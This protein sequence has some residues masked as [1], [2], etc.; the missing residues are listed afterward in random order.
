MV[1]DRILD[2]FFVECDSKSSERFTSDHSNAF[3][4]DGGLGPCIDWLFASTVQ[5]DSP[6]EKAGGASGGSEVSRK[7]SI[8]K[9]P[10]CGKL[11]KGGGLCKHVRKRC[12]GSWHLS[13]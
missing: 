11:N 7:K 4:S 8:C 1:H 10:G 6:Q 9:V 2:R 5:C 12:W 13:P 3:T